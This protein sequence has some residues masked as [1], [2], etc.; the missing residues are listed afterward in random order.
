MNKAKQDRRLRS[1][2]YKKDIDGWF[3][4]KLKIGRY[5]KNFRFDNPI[6]KED[7]LIWNEQFTHE[8]T[9]LK[10][11]PDWNPYCCNEIE[12]CNSRAWDRM[13]KT[14]DGWVCDF[15]GMKIGKHLARIPNNYQP[16]AIAGWDNYNGTPYKFVK[17]NIKS[18]SKEV[19]R[20]INFGIKDIMKI[21]R[22]SIL[23]MRKEIVK[24]K[25][26]MQRNFKHLNSFEQEYLNVWEPQKT[27]ER[28][29]ENSGGNRRDEEFVM[30]KENVFSISGKK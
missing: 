18:D 13:K 21:N 9:Q 2:W 26:K 16:F 30:P 6:F 23:E 11:Y 1:L 14:D 25:H 4:F 10:N 20:G 28:H 12:P 24:D 29:T 5:P 3:Q 19:G 17:S 22:Y 8:E 15:C 27:S 7:M